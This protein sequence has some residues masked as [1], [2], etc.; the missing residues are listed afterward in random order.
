MLE[1]GVQRDWLKMA[2]VRVTW[3]WPWQ[4]QD[5]AGDMEEGG[6]HG[7]EEEE[8]LPA[9]HVQQQEQEDCHVNHQPENQ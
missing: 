1:V 8:R 2:V 3:S 7:A 6:E 4:H 9:P 5:G